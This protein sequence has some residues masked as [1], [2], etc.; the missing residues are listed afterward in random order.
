MDKS[1]NS[2]AL[3]L[4]NEYTTVIITLEAIETLL[5]TFNV[6][7]RDLKNALYV[8]RDELRKM[9]KDLVNSLATH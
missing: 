3:E 6:N 7:D 1:K 5:R 9:Q 2:N 4:A 8:K